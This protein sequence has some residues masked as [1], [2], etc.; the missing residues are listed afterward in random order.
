MF[1]GSFVDLL[2][3]AHARCVAHGVGN[4][5]YFAAKLSG[6]HCGYLHQTGAWDKYDKEKTDNSNFCPNV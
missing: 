2:I 4:Y 5:A 6:T 1:Y 3:G